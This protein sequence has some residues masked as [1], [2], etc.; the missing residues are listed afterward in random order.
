MRLVSSEKDAFPRFYLESFLSYIY[1]ELSWEDVE[2]FVLTRMHMRRRF[3]SG[4][5]QLD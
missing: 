3:S 4:R 2:E 5:H 1:V